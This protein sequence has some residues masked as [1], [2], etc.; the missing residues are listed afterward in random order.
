MGEFFL[1][2]ETDR[3]RDIGL[4]GLS[5]DT[6][7]YHIIYP[8]APELRSWLQDHLSKGE[9]L[10]TFSGYDLREIQRCCG[11]D[12]AGRM[13]YVDLHK[14]CRRQ[15]IDG[16]Q[17]QV[18]AI[19]GFVRAHPIL[20]WGQIFYRFRRYLEDGA[21]WAIDQLIGYN[22]DDLLGMEYIRARLPMGV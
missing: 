16:S 7:V 4:V 6:H 10:Y 19:L 15:W 21:E 22:T 17:K 18:E 3:D 12:L 14:E 20:A 2:I 9:R 11:V 13:D 1:D 8:N 5:D